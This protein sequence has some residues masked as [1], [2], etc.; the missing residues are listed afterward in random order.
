MLFNTRPAQWAGRWKL[1]M[2]QIVVLVRFRTNGARGRT[3][4]FGGP[5]R[6]MDFPLSP[7]CPVQ[8][9]RWRIY[10]LDYY[11]GSLLAKIFIA[12]LHR[13]LGLTFSHV[14]NE[15]RGR[16]ES[17]IRAISSSQKYFSTEV[18]VSR[19]SQVGCGLFLLQIY[20]PLTNDYDDYV[21]LLT[22]GK[23][24][25]LMVPVYWIMRGRRPFLPLHSR[26]HMYH[27][28]D[29]LRRRPSFRPC[30]YG[31]CLCCTAGVGWFM[32]LLVLEMNGLSSSSPWQLC[33]YPLPYCLLRVWV[34]VKFIGF[35][36]IWCIGFYEVYRVNWHFVCIN[37]RKCYMENLLW[38]GGYSC[39]QVEE[40]KQSS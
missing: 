35:T 30:A 16:I 10:F 33:T 23:V 31:Y 7:L 15:Q 27:W 37:V 11:R 24:I 20:D 28:Y 38:I 39:V 25:Q 26:I 3:P 8:L 36:G 34:S 13:W 6:Q 17:K 18:G 2:P 22:L 14:L 9:T 5:S 19:V 4:T 12:G 32:A 1:N 29:I 21:Y 40:K